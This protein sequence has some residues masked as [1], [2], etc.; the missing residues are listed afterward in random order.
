MTSLTISIATA[1]NRSLIV[2]C[3]RSTYESVE[4]LKSE[5][6]LVIRGYPPVFKDLEDHACGFKGEVC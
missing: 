1:K 3:L 4:D 2:D 5:V 6:N